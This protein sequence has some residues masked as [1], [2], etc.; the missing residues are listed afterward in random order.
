MSQ[1]KISKKRLAEII[2][3]EYQSFQHRKTRRLNEDANDDTFEMVDVIVQALGPQQ[4]LEELVQAMERSNAQDL[5]SYV[6]R[7][8]DMRM[9]GDEVEDYDPSAYNR[10]DEKLTLDQVE[11]DEIS[12]EDL[13]EGYGDA[14]DR[15]RAD[16]DR[17]KR[18]DARKREEERKRNAARGSRAGTPSSWGGGGSYGGG[19]GKKRFPGFNRK[20]EAAKPDYI[21]LDKDGDKNEP[22]K[23]AAKDKKIKK[24]GLDSIRDLIQQ[25]LKKI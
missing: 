7:M 1:Y 23:K 12:D 4:A 19:S 8:H 2:K 9:P 6:M 3:E 22:M 18:I 20:D 14:L 16:R 24:E 11:S 13:D 10:T 21:D 15:D 5:L 25:E 17:Q